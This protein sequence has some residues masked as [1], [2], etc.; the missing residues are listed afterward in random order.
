ME[1]EE[2]INVVCS[3]TNYDREEASRLLKESNMN[4]MKVIKEYLNKDK[5][6]KEEKVENLTI[7]EHIHG[8]IR[9]FLNGRE[10]K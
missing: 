1:E 5:A 3:Q 6:G 8:E 4:Y 10:I 2:C 7:N 9:K